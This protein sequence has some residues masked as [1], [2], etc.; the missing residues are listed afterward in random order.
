MDRLAEAQAALTRSA[1]RTLNALVLPAVEWGAANPFPVGSGAI[2]LETTGRISGE[3]RR[4]PLVAAR[5]GDRLAVSTVRGDSQWLANVEADP[6]VTVY[7][8]G[9]PRTATATVRRGPLNTVLLSLD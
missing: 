2:V 5:V 4:V 6:S 9:T 7:L 8:C 3:P 1:F